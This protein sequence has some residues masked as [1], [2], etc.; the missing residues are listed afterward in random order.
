MEIDYQAELFHGCIYDLENAGDNYTIFAEFSN[1]R[2]N[3]FHNYRVN[4][5]VDISIGRTPENDIQYT[6]PLVSRCHATLRWDT[7]EWFIRDQNST[8]GIYVNNKRVK[9]AALYPG[10]C[11]FIVGLRI[12]IGFGFVSIND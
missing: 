6:N 2:S 11:I 1:D 7:K 10:D 8:N 12:N 5:F 4:R 3:V 9:E